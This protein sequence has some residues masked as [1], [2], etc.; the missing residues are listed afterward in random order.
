MVGLTIPLVNRSHQELEES[1]QGNTI[2]MGT[3]WGNL[4]DAVAN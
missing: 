1:F 3:S 4:P 2:P